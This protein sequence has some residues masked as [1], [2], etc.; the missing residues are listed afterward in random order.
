MWLLVDFLV[1]VPLDGVVYRVKPR[2]S[3]QRFRD[4]AKRRWE[5][6]L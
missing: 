3:A 2:V 1:Q 6:L 4:M 5:T